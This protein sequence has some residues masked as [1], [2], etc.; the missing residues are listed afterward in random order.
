VPRHGWLAAAAAL[1]WAGLAGAA[2]ADLPVREVVGGP[3]L[4]R[5]DAPGGGT[6]FLLGS[7]HLGRDRIVD[8]GP[9]IDAAWQ[10]ADELVVE[11]DASQIGAE[12]AARLTQRYGTLPEGKT[13]RDAVSPRTWSELSGFLEE[14]DYT[15]LGVERW[16][17]WFLAFT[18]VQLELRRAGYQLEL[19]VD[20]L[21]L[22]RAQGDK[23]I[24][25][26]ETLDSQFG[27]FDGLPAA[28]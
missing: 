21:F 7:V 3:A 8:F 13:V 12:D 20:R 19:G 5:A 4:W 6:L 9:T 1:A 2:P 27:L 15:A 24:V 22:Q 17:P 25:A 26:L 23:P 14:R 18:L 10:R 16:K 28:Q 11:V